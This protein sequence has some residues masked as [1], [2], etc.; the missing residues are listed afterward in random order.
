MPLRSPGIKLKEN[1]FEVTDKFD[2]AWF[3]VQIKGV[4]EI[5]KAGSFSKHIKTS[6]IGLPFR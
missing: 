4:A 3:Y 1:I 2:I 5:G 6:C